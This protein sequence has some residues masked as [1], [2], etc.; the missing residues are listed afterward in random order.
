MDGIVQMIINDIRTAAAVG[1]TS[2]RY[3]KKEK[4]VSVNSYPPAPVLTDEEMIA[5]F[6]ARFP[7][8]KV[9]YEETWVEVGRDTKKLQKG[10]VIDWS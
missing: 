3:V 6:A 5:G 10:I 8:C 7:G 9:F 4:A 2:Y 1:M